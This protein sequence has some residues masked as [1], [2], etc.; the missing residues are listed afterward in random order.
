MVLENTAW[1]RP[2]VRPVST[3]TSQAWWI[4]D[5]TS[6][7]TGKHISHMS[8]LQIMCAY[9]LAMLSVLSVLCAMRLKGFG[10]PFRAPS[11]VS[12]AQWCIVLILVDSWLFCFSTATALFGVG[13]GLNATMCEV[14][15][16]PYACTRTRSSPD[17]V[18]R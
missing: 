11:K 14:S 9:Y 13:I 16:A 10:N 1:P 5:R 3:Q 4:I 18:D 2:E 6:L 15:R 17:T 12:V 7:C 8:A